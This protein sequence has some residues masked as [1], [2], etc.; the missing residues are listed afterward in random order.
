MC[1]SHISLNLVIR[2]INIF[3]LQKKK[4]KTTIVSKRQTYWFSLS[5]ALIY[6]TTSLRATSAKRTKNVDSTETAA[7]LLFILLVNFG[8]LVSQ[9][10][11]CFFFASFH[12]MNTIYTTECNRWWICNSDFAFIILNSALKQRA[13]RLITFYFIWFFCLFCTWNC[14][15]SNFGAPSSEG[16]TH[17][18]NFLYID[19]CDWLD[20]VRRTYQLYAIFATFFILF[21]FGRQL[22]TTDVVI[23]HTRARICVV[24]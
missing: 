11:R 1:M 24:R 2:N 6:L 15:S 7:I 21:H 8:W 5:V 9:F 19:I 22:R 12:G 23:S 3:F 20:V 13:T 17:K 16:M 18:A 10:R 14:V 4:Q